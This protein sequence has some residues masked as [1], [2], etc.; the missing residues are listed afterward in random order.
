MGESLGPGEGLP[1]LAKEGWGSKKGDPDSACGTDPPGNLFNKN[2]KLLI[3]GK[4][5]TREHTSRERK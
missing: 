1:K 4:Q 3:N 5:L 2:V